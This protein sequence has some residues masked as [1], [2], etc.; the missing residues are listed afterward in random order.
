MFV[1]CARAGQEP[2]QEICIPG[3]PP[4][5]AEGINL[6]HS[7]SVP[8][9]GSEIPLDEFRCYLCQRFSDTYDVRQSPALIDLDL[10]VADSI[11]SSLLLKA[12]RRN[13]GGNVFGNMLEA[14][15]PHSYFLLYLEVAVKRQSYA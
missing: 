5:G 4:T 8:R 10:C 7:G 15:W 6:A 3:N 1:L 11:C 13:W 9:D 12:Q 2:Y 14:V